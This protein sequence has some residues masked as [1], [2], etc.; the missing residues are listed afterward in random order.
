MSE[1]TGLQPHLKSKTLYCCYAG[2][3]QN[4]SDHRVDAQIPKGS[5]SQHG[6]IPQCPPLWAVRGGVE[7][8]RRPGGE[9]AMSQ[10]LSDFK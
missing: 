6:Q 5:L 2:L 4:R 9:G 1:I 7:R 8:D 10:H 3:T